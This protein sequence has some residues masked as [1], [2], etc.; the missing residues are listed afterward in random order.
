MPEPSIRDVLDEHGPPSGL[1]PWCEKLVL[2]LRS[3][4]VTNEEFRDQVLRKF[5]TVEQLYEQAQP[6]AMD[7]ETYQLGG[8]YFPVASQCL[9]RYLSGLDELLHWSETGERDALEA[10]KTHIEAGD[11]LSAEVLVQI[12]DL[13]QQFKETDE[14]L[15]RGV[16]LD[17]DAL[18]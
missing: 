1:T 5:E 13:H 8:T 10:A 7:E 2:L 6:D 9:D 16:G 3:R 14:A 15:M 12:F 11:E 17:P 4:D 18:L